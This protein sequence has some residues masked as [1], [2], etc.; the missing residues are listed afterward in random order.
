[1][2]ALC[3][4]P[5]R[6]LEVRDV[7]RPEQAAA[8]H[9]ILRTA[10]NAINPGDKFFLQNPSALGPRRDDVW[11]ASGAGTVVSVG[12]GVAASL[13]GKKVAVYRSLVVSEAAV[14]CWSEL[15]HVPV[16]C[17]CVLPDDA[18]ALEYSGSLVNAITP[19]AF[20][21]QAKAEGHG[22]ILVTAGAS[23]TGLAMLAIAQ[24]Q[25][26]P[27]VS[28]VTSEGSKAR[29][30][31]LGATRVVA[32][33]DPD[34]DAK[35]RDEAERAHATAVFEGVSGDL[36]TRVLPLLPLR[37]TVYAYGFVGGHRP[38][39][40]LGQVMMARSQTIKNFSNF[41][42]PTV[43]DPQKLAAAHAD[44]ARVI[45]QPHFRTKRGQSFA[46]G[47]IEAALAYAGAN[48]SRAVL[49]A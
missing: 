42:S 11:G 35:L 29:L 20:W 2:K 9:V 36:L 16:N 18:D 4:K 30:G 44:L 46:F 1:M 47:E 43:S 17:C 21:Q 33:T 40:V 24:A 39:S 7:A 32:L 27:V 28:I 3:V 23:A 13:V 19:Y 10:G 22:G 38:F 5:D 31:E 45:G 15:E 41:L 34:F 49:V 48:G 14:G 8:G 25:E 37:S 12:E 26:V 6:T